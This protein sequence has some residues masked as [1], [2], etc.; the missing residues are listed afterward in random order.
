MK[1]ILEPRKNIALL[2]RRPKPTN[3]TYRPMK[4]LL[5][6][7]T[8]D[9]LLLYNVVT[10]EMV[11]LDN[12]E[13]KVFESLPSVHTPEI[14]EMIARHYVVEE[15]LDES[16]S[17]NELRA[18]IKKLEPS[19][20][21]S[22]FTILPTT[23]C[24][25]R[26]YY[27]FQSN[28]KHCTLSESMIPSI[29]DYITAKCKSEP[30]EICW[31]GG[32]PLVANNRITQICT[33]LK[34]KGIK[35]RSTMVSN[36]YLFDNDLIKIAKN[37]WNLISVQITLDGTEEVYNETKA[38]VN[39][40]E[41]PFQRVLNNIEDLLESDIAVNIRFNVTNENAVNLS[42]LIDELAD[43]FGGKKG[44]TCY[45]HAVYEGVGF[46][47]ISYNDTIREVIDL[48]TLA[49]DNKLREN[50]LLGSFSRL[51][52]LKVIN[53]MSDSDSSRLI[54][55][56]GTIGK[57]ENKSSSDCVGDVYHDIVDEEMYE[58]YKSTTM[59]ENCHSCWLFPD[60]INLK[61]CPET[62]QCSNVKID[63]K[64]NRYCDM[65]IKKYHNYKT[66][67]IDSNLDGED[68]KECNS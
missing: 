40:K 41:N 22:G 13:K 27:C 38:Y 4:Y 56:D 15:G 16:K 62:G 59:F 17:V 68:Q 5:T 31:F 53:C 1:T 10:S 45:S 65:M 26:C 8:E 33:G 32:E 63:W 57:C 42:D 60:C 49:L 52:G 44:F 18:L 2:W 67:V 6:A 47:P 37:E 54:Y 19:K 43:R 3:S 21:V 36:G 9:G 14:D 39:P 35:F 12:L 61:A 51:P 58:Q 48:Q 46:E 20:R 23:E 7:E 55:P 50:H 11:L 25:A 66:N 64:R 34:H 30:I 29:I 24:N 28:H